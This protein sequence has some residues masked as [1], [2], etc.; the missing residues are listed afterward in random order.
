MFSQGDVVLPDIFLEYHY[1]DQEWDQDDFSLMSFYCIFKKKNI[2][3]SNSNVIVA[4][5]TIEWM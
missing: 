1:K 4:S 3:N 2:R 5:E